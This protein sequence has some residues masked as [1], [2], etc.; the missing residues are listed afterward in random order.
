MDHENV[1]VYDI[2]ELTEVPVHVLQQ[3]VD[4]KTLVF[5][6]YPEKQFEHE[7]KVL[8]K[9]ESSNLNVSHRIY[10]EVRDGT[11]HFTSRYNRH[12]YTD[13]QIKSMMDKF[14]ELI[15]KLINES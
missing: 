5:L 8:G 13:E 6:N 3:A 7:V 10:V 11:L 14:L 12:V 4:R 9:D 15:V 1:T 2:A